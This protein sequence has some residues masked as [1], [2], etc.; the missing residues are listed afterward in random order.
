M[1]FKESI[2]IRLWPVMDP[3]KYCPHGIYGN[4]SN[5]PVILVPRAKNGTWLNPNA[6]EAQIDSFMD[7]ANNLEV[8][9]IFM[10]HEFGHHY[11][12]FSGYEEA[13]ASFDQSPDSTSIEDRER[14]MNEE[15]F[16]WNK[17][18]EI[19]KGLGYDNWTLFDQLKND[20][21]GSYRTGYKL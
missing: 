20:S 18:R 4:C 19:M 12:D 16:A 8:E 13:R 3:F 5:Q 15:A 1:I 14:L 10:S 7:E 17:A 6:T 21:L 9:M 2:S 11:S